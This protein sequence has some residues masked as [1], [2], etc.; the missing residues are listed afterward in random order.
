MDDIDLDA[1]VLRLPLG[2]QTIRPGWLDRPGTPADPPP[3]T[4]AGPAALSA[5]TPEN[6][7]GV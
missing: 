6:P 1:D 7:P 2:M 4:P 5:N 3:D